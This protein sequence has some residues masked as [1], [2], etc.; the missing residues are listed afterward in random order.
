MNSGIY[1]FGMFLASLSLITRVFPVPVGP[2]HITYSGAIKVNT[3]QFLYNTPLYKMDLDII[4]SCCGSP[5]KNY[6]GI[7]QIYYRKM[8]M[9]GG[10]F[11]ITSL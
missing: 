3:M 5:I 1:S 11:P 10:H 9:K 4:W 7:L 6:H 2:T 8:T